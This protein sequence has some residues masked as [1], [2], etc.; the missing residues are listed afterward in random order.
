MSK[1]TKIVGIVSAVALIFLDL[2]EIWNCFT[3]NGIG[4]F[5][6]IIN[7]SIPCGLILG[8][9]TLYTIHNETPKKSLSITT[10]VLFSVTAFVRV[11]TLVLY[12]LERIYAP[13]SS[14][15]VATDY[16][17]LIE[18]FAFGILAFAVIFLMYYL[19]K[20]KFEKTSLA[21]CGV[22][23]IL[24]FT[25]WIFGICSLISEAISI[26]SGLFEV[27]TVFFKGGFL[28]EIVAILA[29]LS[30]FWNLTII[31]KNKVKA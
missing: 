7:H 9:L 29:Y 26:S 4:A 13:Y 10:L 27:I 28:W 22:A 8:A 6:N 31:M 23:L 24:L 12:I 19:I 25:V 14:A 21:L 1:L 20:G 11:A 2:R 3:L 5:S 18:F 30:V 17:D 15:M 16:L